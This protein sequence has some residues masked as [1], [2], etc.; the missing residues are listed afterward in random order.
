MRILLG[1]LALLGLAA[2]PSAEGKELQFRLVYGGKAKYASTAKFDLGN[3][4][5]SQENEQTKVS[6]SDTWEKEPVEIPSSGKLPFIKTIRGTAHPGGSDAPASYDFQAETMGCDPDTLTVCASTSVEPSAPDGTP[7]IATVEPG[8]R[9]GDVSIAAYATADAFTALGVHGSDACDPQ[10]LVFKPLLLTARKEIKQ[11]FIARATFSLA[12]LRRTRIA[13]VVHPLPKS[14]KPAE[15]P[16]AN[17]TKAPM[18]ACHQTLTL[19][20][21]DIDLRLIRFG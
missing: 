11:Y 5:T 9:K 18:T 17:C 10:R 6:W 15:P 13:G 19:E 20:K 1:A 12:A 2:V 14:V 21:S 4:C 3:G 7:L 16:R 8:K